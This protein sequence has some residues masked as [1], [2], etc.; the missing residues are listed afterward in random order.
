MIVTILNDDPTIQHYIDL[1]LSDFEVKEDLDLL[2]EYFWEAVDEIILEDLYRNYE[3]ETG[4]FDYTYNDDDVRK[5][6]LKKIRRD[7]L[8]KINKVIYENR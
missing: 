3:P 1:D 4:S 6:L 2:D 8:D 5:I 7:K